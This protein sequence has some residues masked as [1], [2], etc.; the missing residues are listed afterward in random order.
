MSGPPNAIL[1]AVGTELVLGASQETNA[2]FASQLLGA[3]GVRVHSIQVVRDE[4]QELERVL[5]KSL[6][7][8]EIIVL[9]GGL[10]PTV[11]DL[12]REAVAATVGKELELREELL[13]DIRARFASRGRDMPA[14]NERQAHLPGGARAIRNP[15]GTAPGF[16][17]ERGNR[18]IIALPG[19][20][21]EFCHLFE[22]AVIPAVQARYAEDL[23]PY[24]TRTLLSTGISESRLGELVAHRMARGENPEVGITAKQ[25]ASSLRLVAHS[26]DGDEAHALL[27]RLEAELRELLGGTLCEGYPGTPEDAL[28]A[29]PAVRRLAIV[30]GVTGGELSARLAAAGVRASSWSGDKEFLKSCFPRLGDS[31]GAVEAA[32]GGAARAG[33][34]AGIAMLEGEEGFGF[35]AAVLGDKAA[36]GVVVPTESPEVNRWRCA[37][38]AMD[39]MRR[40]A[41]GLPAAENSEELEALAEIGDTVARAQEGDALEELDELEAAVAEELAEIESQGG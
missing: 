4:Q 5:K 8:A 27:D 28:A 15:L 16:L 13:E 32:A 3:S 29:L 37:A 17:L 31:F 18:L 10:G 19:V 33:V 25:G 35:V 40:L 22:E 6:I 9:S 23:R 2:R 7:D 26:T 30:D 39:L 14:S 12:T 20:P 41:Q 34:E 21:F 38:R 11:D 1:I 36:E 24:S